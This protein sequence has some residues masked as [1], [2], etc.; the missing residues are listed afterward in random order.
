MGSSR[1]SVLSRSRWRGRSFSFSSSARRAAAHSCC[2]TVFGKLMRMLLRRGPVGQP[3]VRRL[4]T[5]RFIGPAH[6]RMTV[7]H[8]GGAG[9]PGP[10]G[11]ALMTAA[12]RSAGGRLE[13]LDHVP[14]RVLEQDLAAPRPGEDVVAERR[15]GG[16]EAGDL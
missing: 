16:T 7:A 11:S 1:R 12:G 15:A 8:D 9:A 2:E 3:I 10:D 5:G 13:E 14:R 4:G 6:C